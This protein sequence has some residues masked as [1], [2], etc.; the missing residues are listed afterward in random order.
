[1]RTWATSSG[2]ILVFGVVCPPIPP[3]IPPNYLIWH[4]TATGSPQKCAAHRGDSIPLG[5]VHIHC[6]RTDVRPFS[7]LV[8]VGP[9]MLKFPLI[10]KGKGGRGGRSPGLGQGPGLVLGCL[11]RSWFVLGWSCSRRGRVLGPSWG[12]LGP[13]RGGPR[14]TRAVLVAPTKLDEAAGPKRAAGPRRAGGLKRGELVLLAS[15]RR[16]IRP[17]VSRWRPKV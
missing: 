6:H 15:Q 3:Y 1:M 11:G 2:P 17:R 7:G 9:C 5:F 8:H 16:L 14:A 10:R 4:P 13:S 12:R